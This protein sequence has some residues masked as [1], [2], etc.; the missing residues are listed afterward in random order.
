MNV[1]PTSMAFQ[2]KSGF[3]RIVIGSAKSVQ[4]RRKSFNSTTQSMLST[5]DAV[6]VEVASSNLLLFDW[7]HSEPLSVSKP[8]SKGA[9]GKGPKPIQW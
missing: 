7:L 4:I 3:A 2:P 9:E 1:N 6:R 5:G 8:A